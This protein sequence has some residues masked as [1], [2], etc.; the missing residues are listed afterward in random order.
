M[1]VPGYF[2]TLIKKDKSILLSIKE[3]ILFD[4]L[5][6]DYNNII[7]TA[8]QQYIKNTDI[9]KKKTKTHIENDIIQAVIA[10]T[11]E[12]FNI[13]KPLELFYIAMDGVPPRAKMEQQKAR[14]HKKILESDL[15]TK[16]KK[17]Y[18][19]DKA[20]IF[21]SNVISPG[22]LFMQK[23]SKSL[24]KAIKDGEF[25]KTVKIVLSD[26][27]VVGEG[28]HKMI[29][30]IKKNI[31]KGSICVYGD[32]ADLIFL[33]MT[34]ISD[35]IKI[36]IM[37]SQTL[38]ETEYGG[39]GL[40]YLDVSK[41]SDKF[42][43]FIGIT[44]SK[45]DR[46]LYDYIFMMILFG[47][48]FVK[49]IPSLDIGKQSYHMLQIYKTNFHKHKKHLIS[50]NNKTKKIKINKP[51]FINI[52]I[53]LSKIEEKSLR[54]TQNYIQY[55]CKTPFEPQDPT[56]TGYELE[57]NILYHSFI[58]QKENP[59]YEEYKHEFDKINYFQDKHIWKKEYY[60]HF[61]DLDTNT[62][63]TTNISGGCG[64]CGI[65]DIGSISGGSSDKKKNDK[66]NQTNQNSDTKKYDNL[67]TT[68]C[69][70][71]LESIIFTIEY[72]LF[73][74][75]SYTFYY[76]YRVA[77]FVSDF[78]YNIKKTTDID[79]TTYKLDKPYTPLQQLMIIMPIEFKNMLPI[80]CRKLMSSKAFE[81][82][83]KYDIKLD[84]VANNKFF[85]AEL[86][87][88][89]MNDKVILD[90]LKKVYD[91]L[92]KAELNRNTMTKELY[93]HMKKVNK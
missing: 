68:I 58:A 27:S 93:F 80:P 63:T 76:P 31:T 29:P 84:V 92:N 49:K 82:Y 61:F 6:M 47:D 22:T 86:L 20:Q 77:P 74:V 19:I 15:D 38:E 35:D 16:L 62:S 23:L 71:Y 8:S 75:P 65:G 37:K 18:K 59:F 89:E 85:K 13:V 72:Y 91:E 67:R 90:E 53:E 66:K 24:Q 41:I 44:H 10:K 51:F 9:N 87:L 70:K 14:R 3:K 21:D 57:K 40:A 1:G 11:V 5:F 28:E 26:T 46:I 78:L 83:Y 88:P 69:K 54:N 52:L 2:R 79:K 56:I 64:G 45:K 50:I 36:K 30:Y 43:E 17:K 42:Y 34:L 73:G 7:H 25:G 55:K 4:Y 33:S 12:I 32:D 60:T 48:D 39:I 81:Q